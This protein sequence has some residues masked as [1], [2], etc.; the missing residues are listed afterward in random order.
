VHALQDTEAW[1]VSGGVVKQVVVV[2]PLTLPQP[3]ASSD[4]KSEVRASDA[5]LTSPQQFISKVQQSDNVDHILDKGV[6]VVTPFHMSRLEDLYQMSCL[7]IFLCH[8]LIPHV[9]G[10]LME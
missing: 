9:Q 2:A 5:E 4:G 10:Q 3:P 1:I 7:F 6:W 8:L